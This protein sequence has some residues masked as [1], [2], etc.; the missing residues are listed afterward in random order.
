[1]KFFCNFSMTILKNSEHIYLR[2]IFKNNYQFYT[3]L[4]KTLESACSNHLKL[5][6]LFSQEEI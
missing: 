2:I 3:D 4:K 6:Q 1:M 5:I